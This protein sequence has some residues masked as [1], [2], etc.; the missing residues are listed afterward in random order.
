MCAFL[1]GL[2]IALTPWT[3]LL[4][5]PLA[6]GTTLFFFLFFFLNTRANS[7]K[8]NMFMNYI[9]P[10][11]NKASLWNPVYGKTCS[12]KL[13]ATFLEEQESECLHWL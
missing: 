9:F 5:R 2:F 10:T 12:H 8:I 13:G 1:K 4:P 11:Q 6:T 7:G 3:Q